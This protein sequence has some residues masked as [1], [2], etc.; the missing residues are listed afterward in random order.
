MTE[1]NRQRYNQI[2]TI[3]FPPSAI[4]ASIGLIKMFAFPAPAAAFSPVQEQR[5]SMVEALSAANSKAINDLQ[6]LLLDRY[7]KQQ[8]ALARVET[9]IEA[10][11]H[12]LNRLEH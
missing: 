9:A 8:E 4:V 6:T 10:I 7:S 1:R 11:Q 3:A 5:L 12:S 2:C